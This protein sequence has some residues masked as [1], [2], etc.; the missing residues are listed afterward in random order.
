MSL[1]GLH[2]GHCKAELLSNKIANFRAMMTQIF[3][4]SGSDFGCRIK[5]LI[6][7]LLKISGLIRTDK[8]RSVLIFESDF[9]LA[10]KIYF[11]II[12][13]KRA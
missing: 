7:M 9:N 1:S 10:N 2:F 8:L 3:F 11:G 12:S 13:M 4:Q 6:V 5:G